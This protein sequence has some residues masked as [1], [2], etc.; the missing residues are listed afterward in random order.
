MAELTKAATNVEGKQTF[1]ADYFKS[2]TDKQVWLGNPHIDN[3]VSV[4]L[5]LGAE[6][7]A[8]KQRQIISEKLAAKKT[9]PTTAAI[10]AYKPSKDEEAEWD[11][12]RQALAKRLYSWFA[13]ETVAPASASK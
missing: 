5:A 6:I 3:L 1:A 10:E 8:V 13:R 11:A 9:F 7:W 2:D 12:E 4:T